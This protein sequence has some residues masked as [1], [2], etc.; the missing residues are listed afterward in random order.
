MNRQQASEKRRFHRV[1][2]DAGATLSDQARSWTCTVEDLS[3]KG[4]MLRLASAWTVDPDRT[5][6]LDILLAADIHIA[7]DV[8]PAHQE[9]LLAGFRCVG[10][11]A[12][13]IGQ[14]RR[15]VELNLG[16]SAIL[17]RDLKALIGRAG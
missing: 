17:E 13:S 16:D 7:M 9:G 14:L 10:I 15:L 12:E 3:L 4:C 5:Y 6:H 11:D 8:V 1:G 2:H